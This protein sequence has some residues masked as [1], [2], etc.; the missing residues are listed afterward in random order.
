MSRKSN[1][2]SAATP[3]V[4]PPSTAKPA[5]NTQAASP[6]PIIAKPAPATKL[7]T[8]ANPPVVTS[9]VAQ[10]PSTE[11][12][13]WV[14]LGLLMLTILAL[15]LHLLAVPLERDEGEY[16][17]MGKLL[18]EG[19]APFQDAANM[20]LPGTSIVYAL[21]MGVFGQTI[22]GVH[23]GLL[24]VNLL[25]MLFLFM[26]LR[27]FYNAAV[28]LV[29]AGAYGLMA[30][31]SGVL[32]FAAHATQ[33]VVVFVAAALVVLIK[34]QEKPKTMLAFWAGVLMGLSFL[35]KQQAVFFPVFGGLFLLAALYQAKSFKVITVL[36]EGAIYSVGV[37]LP[38]L[39]ILGWVSATGNFEQFWFWTV[40]YASQYA[41]GAP[42]EEIPMLFNLSFKP[43][44]D[45]FTAIWWLGLAGLGVV[46]LGNYTPLQKGFA[47]GFALLSFA[48]VLPGFYFRQHYFVVALPALAM[49]FAVSLDVI[50][51]RLNGVMRLSFWQFV[52]LA[53]LV[54]VGLRAFSAN[55]AYYRQMKP[56]EVARRIYGG[57]PFTESP[58]IGDY[59]RQNSAPTDKIAVLGSEPQ[60]FLYADRRS[61][62]RHIYT[63][64]MMEQQ[65][66]NVKMQDEM[67]SEIEAAKP[68][69]VVFCRVPTSWLARKESPMKI[70]TWSDQYL[71]KNYELVGV[72]DILPEG[73]RYFWNN[74]VKNFTGQNQN[75]VLVFRRKLS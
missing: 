64:G 70:F 44:Y 16:A 40:E 7:A 56:D 49:L 13:A 39:L 33:Y 57:N 38:Y 59:I 10:K 9:V 58:V 6:K 11:V 60:L 67:I 24:I 21:M 48:A 74:E 15:R 66:F 75:T 52:P 30:V 54:F 41:G 2:K 43:L 29:T 71:Q 68:K 18:L 50:A 19:S 37:L 1:R 20:K 35:M 32:G 55:K 47:V 42:K 65:P 4:P 51:Q 61:A 46:F 31:S 23:T 8:P 34:Y 28:G 5:P 12:W 45:E 26:A 69:F 14:V 22:T 62:S 73:T 72:A 25:S 17:Y 3:P 36:R 27:R 53:I 63:Y